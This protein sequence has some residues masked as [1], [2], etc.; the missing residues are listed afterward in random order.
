MGIS[1]ATISRRLGSGQFTMMSRGRSRTKPGTLLKWQIP[2][3]AWA[4]WDDAVPRIVE[5]DL[6]GQ[7]GGN[8]SGEHCFT[9]TVTDIATVWTVN[10]S[11]GNK[12][13]KWPFETLQHMTGVLPFPTS[14]IHSDNGN[15]FIKHHLFGYRAANEIT[16]TKS[17]AGHSNDGAHVK[18][19][20]WTHLR[21]LVG[22][23]R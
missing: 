7:E 19:K 15:E 2:I 21:E 10:R 4:E 22:Y 11:V 9:L 6:V 20:T 5:I 3:H 14:Y 12:A 1:G 13:E 17:Q 8:A 18:Q 23:L 16:F